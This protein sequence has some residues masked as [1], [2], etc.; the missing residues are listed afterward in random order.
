[1]AQ[2]AN[3]KTA[4]VNLRRQ[5]PEPFWEKHLRKIED[6]QRDI[7]ALRLEMRMDYAQRVELDALGDRVERLEVTRL[8]L[9]SRR[10]AL[11]PVSLFAIAAFVVI[12]GALVLA[13]ARMDR[14]IDA[15]TQKL[16]WAGDSIIQQRNAYPLPS[17]VQPSPPPP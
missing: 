12:L 6:N 13:V 8:D 2:T 4:P 14:R 15:T 5:K 3:Q 10:Q 17:P 11:S 7:E 1:M 9:E 16:N